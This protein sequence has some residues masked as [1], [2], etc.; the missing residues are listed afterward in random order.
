MK[1]INFDAKFVEQ[2]KE[3]KKKTTVRKGI[4]IYERGEIVALTSNGEFFGR[5]RIIKVLVKRI[6][7]LTEGDA[8]LDGFSSKEELMK[9]LKRIYGEIKDKDLVSII[10]FEVL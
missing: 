4:K 6:S 8:K 2:I 9:E 7:E 1:A 5:A 10:H 3:G